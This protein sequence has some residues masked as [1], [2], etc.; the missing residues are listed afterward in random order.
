MTHHTLLAIMHRRH[1]I[2]GLLL[3]LTTTAMPVARTDAQSGDAKRGAAFYEAGEFPRARAEFA[4]ILKQNE[5]DA[6]AL[7]WMGRIA[8]RQENSKEAVDWLE[9]AIAVN[10]RVSDYHLWLGNALG[11]QAINAS[12]FRQP[13]L[14]RR[15]KTEFERAVSLDARNVQA[16]WGLVQFYTMAPG[17]MG[18]GIDKARQQVAALAPVSALQAHLASA[19]I[20]T[21]Q[22]DTA[23]VQREYEAAI[24]T[25]PDS[26][27]GYYSLGALFQRTE[28]WSDAFMT[29]ER[30]LKRIP[31]DRGAL[32]Q[33]ARTAALSGRNLERGEQTIR[34][35]LADL[36]DSPTVSIAGA[37]HRLGQI[38]QHQGKRDAARTEFEQAIRVNPKNDDARKALNALK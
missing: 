22:K 12:K 9:K 25:A 30:L 28:R 21:H 6:A 15:V 23:T 7:A 11:D 38:L 1:P 32:F 20:A 26:A 2:A 27:V 31:G 14:A 16:R 10:D 33:V 18:G 5:R 29:Y 36:G 17:F 24:A 13:F 8:M 4:A 19:F 34:L 35:W 37:H 3:A